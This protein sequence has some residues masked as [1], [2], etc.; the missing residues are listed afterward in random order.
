MTQK[1]AHFVDEPD[2]GATTFALS[3]RNMIGI[4]WGQLD[5]D[6]EVLDDNLEAQTDGHPAKV[7]GTAASPASLSPAG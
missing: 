6:P 3:R 4:M 1:L 5:G 2:R 7:K